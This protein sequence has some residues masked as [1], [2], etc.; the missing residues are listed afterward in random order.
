M[1]KIE[2]RDGNVLEKKASQLTDKSNDKNYS[3]TGN[4]KNRDIV[5]PE[6]KYMQNT[7]YNYGGHKNHDE[8]ESSQGKRTHQSIPFSTTNASVN[9]TNNTI[10]KYGTKKNLIHKTFYQSM[11]INNN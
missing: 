6:K 10:K 11:G 7:V 3:K 4:Q 8:L 1:A 9:S 5:N 2:E